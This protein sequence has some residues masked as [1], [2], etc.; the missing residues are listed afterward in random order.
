MGIIERIKEIGELLNFI[1]KVIRNTFSLLK[2]I[3]KLNRK[4]AFAHT[5]Q[6]GHDNSYWIV[7]ITTIQ[8]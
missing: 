1:Y 4:G 6:Q 3:F 5:D 2:I 7:E 8:A